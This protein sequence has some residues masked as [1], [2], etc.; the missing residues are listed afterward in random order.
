MPEGM[1]ST[2]G[3]DGSL[4]DRTESTAGTDGKASGFSSESTGTE[5]ADRTFQN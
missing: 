3:S 5:S 4:S 2:T 1:Q